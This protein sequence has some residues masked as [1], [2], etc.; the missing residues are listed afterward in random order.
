MAHCK[1]FIAGIGAINFTESSARLLRQALLS[2]A[3]QELQQELKEIEDR[4]ALL[5]QRIQDSDLGNKQLI[6]YKQKQDEAALRIKAQLKV[7]EN[8]AAEAPPFKLETKVVIDEAFIQDFAI[9]FRNIR[10]LAE[11]LSDAPTIIKQQQT[12]LYTEILFK[13]TQREQETQLQTLSFDDIREMIKQALVIY[14][15]ET[16]IQLRNQAQTLIHMGIFEIVRGDCERIKAKEKLSSYA[17]YQEFLLLLSDKLLDVGVSDVIDNLSEYRDTKGRN[18]ADLLQQIENKLNITQDDSWN[19]DSKIKALKTKKALFHKLRFGQEDRREYVGQVQSNL[20]RDLFWGRNIRDTELFTVRGVSEDVFS[21][22]VQQNF[23]INSKFEKTDESSPDFSLAERRLKAVIDAVKVTRKPKKNGPELFPIGNSG[24]FAKNTDALS[25]MVETVSHELKEKF[26]TPTFKIINGFIQVDFYYTSL[27]GQTLSKNILSTGGIGFESTTLLKTL[28]GLESAVP[29]IEAITLRGKTLAEIRN[30]IKTLGNEK[31]EKACSRQLGLLEQAFKRE[32]VKEIAD[33]KLSNDEEVLLRKLLELQFIAPIHTVTDNSKILEEALKRIGANQFKNAVKIEGLEDAVKGAYERLAA[34]NAINVPSHALPILQK[35][36]TLFSEERKEKLNTLNDLLKSTK[37]A[38]EKENELTKLFVEE[39][40]GMS[41]TL[42]LSSETEFSRLEADVRGMA[43]EIIK[44]IERTEKGLPA[45]T[46]KEEAAYFDA[47]QQIARELSKISLSMH[48]VQ[49]KIPHG[50]KAKEPITLIDIHGKKHQFTLDL[51]TEQLPYSLI[52]PP[53]ASDFIFSYGGSRGIIAPF[54]GL[55]EAYAGVGKK[56]GRLF[57]HSRLLGVGQYGSVKEVESLLS[58]LNQVTKKGYALDTE[59][60]TDESRSKQRTRP[61]TAR[62]DPYYRVE[63]D[64]MQNLSAVAKASGN[65]TVGETQYWLEMDKPRFKG[66]LYA[67]DGSLQQYRLLTARA[68]GQTFA[69]KAN[70]DLN[71]YPKDRLAYH[72]PTQRKANDLDALTDML[73]L[74]Q[75]LVS[76]AYKL[77]TLGSTA[78]SKQL[79]F[80]HNDI[81]PENFIYKRKADGSFE[82]RYIDWAT[83]GF[84]Q[85]YTG[86]KEKLDEIFVELFGEGLTFELKDNKCT[87]KNGRFVRIEEGSKIVYG[88]NPTLQILH[89]ARNGTLPYISPQVLGKNREKQSQPAGVYN[90][91]FNTV[92]E[93]NDPTSD[94]WALTAMTFGICNLEAYFALVKGRAVA[95]YVIPGI[96]ALEGLPPHEKLVI[97]DDKKFTEFFACRNPSDSS[98]FNTGVVATHPTPVMFI[99]SNQRE[100]EPLHLF[101]RLQELQRS[102]ASDK[103]VDESKTKIAREIETILST[104]YNAIASGKGL[105]KQELTK[106]LDAAQRCL[107]N[108]EKIKDTNYQEGLLK[109]EVLHSLLKAI[110]ERPVSADD[111]LKSF[112]EDGPSQLKILCTYPSSVEQKKQVVEIFQKT[113][114]ESAFV[115][116]FI[117]EKAPARDLFKDMIARHQ[118]EIL[119]SLLAKIPENKNEDF[120]KI[121]SED[122][123]LHYAAEQGLTKVFGSLVDAL[124]RAGATPTAI[125]DLSLIEYKSGPK[126][127]HNASHLRWSTSCFHIAIRNNNPKLLARLLTLLPD[128]NN[129]KNIIDEALH[130]CAVLGNKQLFQQIEKAR[131][132]A[133]SPVTAARIMGI[134]L[135]PEYLSPYH[136]FLNNEATL[137]AIKWKTLTNQP[138]LGKQFLLSSDGNP[139]LIAA[140]K[141]NFAGVFQLLEL[142]KAIDFEDWTKVL[143]ETDANGKNLLNYMLEL[144][145]LEH[146]S[147]FINFI[148]ETT[149][150]SN[151]I[152]VQLL[153]NPHPVNPLKNFLSQQTNSDQHFVVVKMLLDTI[154]SNFATATIEQQQARVVALLIN[155]DWLIEQAKDTK[156][157]EELNKLLQNEALSIPFKQSLFKTLKEASQDNVARTFYEKLLTEVSRI[158]VE[159]DKKTQLEISGV[160]AEVIRQSSDFEELFKALTEEHKVASEFERDAR[161]LKEKVQKYAEKE[162]RLEST[163]KQQQVEATELKETLHQTKDQLEKAS[164]LTLK[165]QQKSEKATKDYLA[166]ETLLKQEIEKEKSSV[167]AVEEELREAKEQHQQEQERLV[168]ALKEVESHINVLKQEL[169]EKSSELDSKGKSYRQLEAQYKELEENKNSLVEELKHSKSVEK[170]TQEKLLAEIKT[171]EGKESDLQELGKQLDAL[172]DEKTKL[173]Q[174]LESLQTLNK[175]LG[176]ENSELQQRVKEYKENS[177]T[178]DRELKKY[179]SEVVTLKEGLQETQEKLQEASARTSQLE[180]EIENT[181]TAF[182]EKEILLKKQIEETKQSAERDVAGV[183]QKLAEAEKS[184]QVTLNSLSVSLKEVTEEVQQLQSSLQEKDL[185]F[186]VKEESYKKLE[187][188]SAELKQLKEKLQKELSDSKRLS[189]STISELQMK[190][191]VE[192]KAGVDK[193][194]KLQELSQQLGNLQ[195]TLKSQTEELQTKNGELEDVKRF[196]E[197]EH[198]RFSQELETIKKQIEEERYKAQEAETKQKQAE[199]SAEE[200]QLET[201]RI[202]EEMKRLRKEMEIQEAKVK[203]RE[204]RVA[205]REQQV[206]ERAAEVEA[207]HQEVLRV[208]EDV[209]R[210]ED[211]LAHAE[212]PIENPRELARRKAITALKAKFARSIDDDLLTAISHATSNEDLAKLGLDLKYLAVLEHD[213]YLL[214]ADATDERLTQLQEE[215]SEI[216]TEL[217]E[218][219]YKAVLG[220][221][222]EKL[223]RIYNNLNKIDTLDKGITNE[224]NYLVQ[225]SPL[226]WF[227]PA[228][229]ASLKKNA[230]ELA[231]H[232]ER[233]AEGCNVVVDYLKPLSI[234]LKHQFRSLPSIEEIEHLPENSPKRSDIESRRALL[235]RYLQ[236]VQ[237]QLDLYEP[238]YKLLNG[239]PAASNPLLRQGIRKTL[240]YAQDEK[241]SLKFSS[242]SSDYRDYSQEE[243]ALHLQAGYESNVE[244]NVTEISS[245]TGLAHYQVVESAKQNYFREHIINPDDQFC[246]YF[247]EDRAKNLDSP[248][249]GDSLKGYRPSITITVSKFPQGPDS[250]DPQLIAARV[251]YALAVATHLLSEFVEPPTAKDPVIMRGPNP[252]ELRYLWTAMVLVGKEV[253][254]FQ[255]PPEAVAV[256]SAVFKPGLEMEKT[257]FWGGWTTQWRANSCYE[258]SFRGQPSV[259]IWLTGLKEAS[260]HRANFKGES[261]RIKKLVGDVT[262]TFFGNAKAKTVVEDLKQEVLKNG[263]NAGG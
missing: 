149:E 154:C 181:T 131:L 99:P 224:L 133:T 256:A 93:A 127:A 36:K 14:E 195:A 199:K 183:K 28:R 121:V 61:I 45:L 6:V 262:Q 34:L 134:K 250:R 69:D 251:Q 169:E 215:R 118:T 175:R 213:D 16:D 25:K 102:L 22:L 68:K 255:F 187:T 258:T 19:D 106:Q 75:A 33:L 3:Y 185:Q 55:D 98:A 79:G 97:I 136:L 87:D 50:L 166:K 237:G 260:R 120:I 225:I 23:L 146:L 103:D 10:H 111:L 232:Y 116:K 112:P 135:P 78:E 160:F 58:G 196:L 211:E 80:A 161:D 205:E 7:L 152:L 157:F 159:I 165:L 132:H 26:T 145:Q 95:D 52:K 42:G 65:A 257:G 109:Q 47:I 217:L 13:L 220:E 173:G 90:S 70:K 110:H 141:A 84:V 189:E 140:A 194:A 32:D 122:G 81:K 56:K 186:K 49:F 227:S 238:L 163:L 229:Q 1:K 178:L 243:R 96:L 193:Q 201:R 51:K 48:E 125:L 200:A 128:E 197:S 41:Q 172:R 176:E 253:S 222:R 261:D 162:Q 235:T 203:A 63:R 236:R 89:G 177:E 38:T 234:E 174:E 91:D 108:Y 123:L 180:Q 218:R 139:L 164:V 40:T 30:Q 11:T 76:E 77:Q 244:G 158:P 148:K 167:A 15:R 202:L 228:F 188:E 206:E 212:I 105:N 64:L 8:L 198:I 12:R 85:K 60:F 147:R 43:R 223:R 239:D 94:D 124:T 53:G 246:G 82:V 35:A 151:D 114:S 117:G 17:Q 115:D 101:R 119:I 74:S 210:R 5:P 184:Y 263:P 179:L 143:S 4:K 182:L 62:K 67:Q 88:I 150:N 156:N 259:D 208:E 137:A 86:K 66:E 248:L 247:I 242:F 233:L 153:S 59:P 226:H 144:N 44:L 240:K 24:V 27:D 9:N 241:Y 21:M 190:L 170:E 155:K 245:N 18:I 204:Q 231:P 83:G 230:H 219:N 252:E 209:H 191:D 216:K 168:C 254:G 31:L 54:A 57:T 249:Y 126:Q 129:D 20:A 207:L 130:F 92:F 71:Y 214:I 39:Y 2:C 29:G 73:A 221:N 192:T 46:P 142:G 138:E 72:D 107:Q 37:S 104:V 100:G 171:R 113:F